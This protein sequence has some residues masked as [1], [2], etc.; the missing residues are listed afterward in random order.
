MCCQPEAGRNLRGLAHVA[1]FAEPNL[2][3][4]LLSAACM[5]LLYWVSGPMLCP[6][7]MCFAVGRDSG[8]MLHSP[9]DCS[10]SGQQLHALQSPAEEPRRT[11]QRS[12]LDTPS[13]LSLQSPRQDVEASGA[14]TTSTMGEQASPAGVNSV[15]ARGP[16]HCQP[17]YVTIGKQASATMDLLSW[18]S[19]ISGHVPRT[20]I[21]NARR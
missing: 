4:G 10:A 9:S 14:S 21:C 19:S 12:S 2:R 13:R 8:V 1:L 15:C 16:V 5:A 3:R 17:H 18:Q 6:V 20:N 11:R 7:A